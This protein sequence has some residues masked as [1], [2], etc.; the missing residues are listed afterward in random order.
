MTTPTPATTLPSAKSS[1]WAVGFGAF[2]LVLASFPYSALFTLVPAVLGIVLG[3][4]VLTKRRTPRWAGALGVVLGATALIVS[5]VVLSVWGSTL[6][7]T[8]VA[9]PPTSSTPTS[10]PS[11][12][13]TVTATAGHECVDPAGD[14]ATNDLAKVTLALSTKNL[15]ATFDLAQ[16]MPSSGMVGLMVA[17]EAKDDAHYNAHQLAVGLL[18]GKI[19]E[20]FDF[21]FGTTQQTNLELSDVSVV[22]D[23]VIAKFPASTIDSLG[24]NWDWYAFATDGGDD[25]DACPG[26]V[27]SGDSVTFI[28]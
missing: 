7:K 6:P 15:T 28:G 22:G 17:T 13:P 16:P 8:P 26:D 19:T 10:V 11:A 14:G 12:A 1:Y 25:T 20:F 18:D 5:V 21:D 2:G 4:R 23:Q 9:A 24:A 27:N 3:A